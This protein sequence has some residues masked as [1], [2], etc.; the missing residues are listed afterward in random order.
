MKLFISADIEGVSG[1]V[2]WVEAN[3]SHSDYRTFQLQM[4]KEVRAAAEGALKSG[5]KEI[6]IKDAH[7]TA[8]NIIHELLPKETE[9]INSWCGH[10]YGM[11]EGLDESFDGVLF[12]G[13]HCGAGFNGNPLAHTISS[14]KIR[15]IK[16][17]D[18]LASEFKLNYYTALY[19]GVPVIFVSGDKDLIEDV[20]DT[21]PNIKGLAVKEGIGAGAKHLHPVLVEEKIKSIVENTLKDYNKQSFLGELPKEFKVEICYNRHADAYKASFYPNVTLKNNNTIEFTC[22]DYFEVL[23]MKLFLI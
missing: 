7:A 21:N 12:I 23:R 3:K 2:D 14:S 13:Y 1:I 17:N 5:A 8:R 9:L 19:L 10:P 6:V 20:N 16:L 15:Y 22:N 11:M 4:T 18:E